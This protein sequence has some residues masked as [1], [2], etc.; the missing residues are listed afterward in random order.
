MAN[1]PQ[2]GEGYREGSRWINERPTGEEL[3][4]WFT[5]NVTLHEGLEHEKYVS[6]IVVIEQ[7]EKVREMI[8]RA[9]GQGKSMLERE[10][11]TYTPYPTASAR[12]VYWRD[13]LALHEDDEWRGDIEPDP[14]V[15]RAPGSQL[16][17][18][19]FRYTVKEESG[20]DTAFVGCSMRAVIRGPDIRAGVAGREVM[21]APAG[22]KVV[23]VLGRYGADENALMKA[24]T[25]AMGRALGFAGMLVL[26]GT[27]IATAEDVR[28][29]IVAES[30]PAAAGPETAQLPTESAGQAEAEPVGAGTDPSAEALELISTLQADYPAEHEKWVAWAKETNT[31]VQELS[32]TKLRGIV[33]RLRKHVEAGKAAVEAA[34]A[35][36]DKT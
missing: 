24:Q 23:K 1:A 14:T 19:F 26:P 5:E 3:A 30:S 2:P 17:A 13:Y 9:D 21:V 32:G 4:A 15:L 35:T 20:K 12:L 36:S 29:S 11:L 18:G 31:N 33:R 34:A 27:G 25:G 28:E 6:G 16:P 7:K 10:R 22:S 8:D